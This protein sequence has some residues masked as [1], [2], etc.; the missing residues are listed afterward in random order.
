MRINGFLKS[1][2]EIDVEVSDS[3]WSTSTSYLS[4]TPRGGTIG[5]L[6]EESSHLKFAP[7]TGFVE[8]KTK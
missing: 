1:N 5:N 7:F 4:S 8:P 2:K 3:N 6:Q